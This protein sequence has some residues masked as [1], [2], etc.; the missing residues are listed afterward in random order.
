[1]AQPLRVWN[2][3]WVK[4]A[5][6]LGVPVLGFLG[7]F[8]LRLPF[9]APFHFSLRNAMLIGSG[10]FLLSVLPQ[11]IVLLRFLNCELHVENDGVEIRRGK[12][13]KFLRWSEIGAVR[14]HGVSQV[15]KLYDRSDRLVYAVDFYAENFH[16]F[17][18][19]LKRQFDP[20]RENDG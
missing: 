5:L 20:P 15:L 14:V 13:G 7:L 6:V 3:P 4:A 18:E 8:V 17:Y 12:V 19:L 11:G 10:L 16:R 9:D 1:M 2:P